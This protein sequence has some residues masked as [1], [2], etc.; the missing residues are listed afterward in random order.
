MNPKTILL[1]QKWIHT[2]GPKLC[3]E[4]RH[5]LTQGEAHQGLGTL[6][7]EVHPI[8]RLV[9]LSS[10]SVWKPILISGSTL[11]ARLICVG[12]GAA[13]LVRTLRCAGSLRCPHQVPHSSQYKGHLCLLLTRRLVMPRRGWVFDEDL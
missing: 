2:N 9:V 13:I 10:S 11:Q 4:E 12:D 1:D 3:H 6:V 5:T 8:V 7:S